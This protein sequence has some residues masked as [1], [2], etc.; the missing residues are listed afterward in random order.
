[1]Y[2][3][4]YFWARCPSYLHYWYLSPFSGAG[5]VSFRIVV[6]S[7]KSAVADDEDTGISIHNR[8]QTQCK[9]NDFTF[10]DVM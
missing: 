8:N 9:L 2:F 1:M 7:H 5:H 10:P 3:N 6:Q 4:V